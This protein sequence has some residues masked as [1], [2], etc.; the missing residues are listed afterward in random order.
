M[1]SDAGQLATAA[2]IGLILLPVS[3]LPAAAWHGIDRARRDAAL[4][5]PAALFLYIGMFVAV[6]LAASMR[7]PLRDASLAHADAAL[8]ISVPAV[9]SWIS[10][11]GALAAALRRSYGA[12]LWFLAASLLVPALVGRRAEA[13]RLIAAN[14]IAFA[15]AAPV[16]V[17]FPA[18]GPWVT[19]HFAPTHAQALC[20]QS[21]LSLRSGG[22]ITYGGM[23]C[24]PSFHA[25]WGVLAASGFWSF[26]WLRLPAAMLASLMVASALTTGWHYGVDVVMGL[27]IAAFSLS[28]ASRVAR[29]RVETKTPKCAGSRTVSLVLR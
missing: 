25:I 2:E 1:I 13:W 29:N 18:V 15:V 20:E 23:V 5:I 21:I 8:G 11:H 27:A 19:Y 4:A 14:G 12:L 10:S 24:A 16:F 3:L 26:K 22:P 6:A 28:I 17:L 9:L 7:M